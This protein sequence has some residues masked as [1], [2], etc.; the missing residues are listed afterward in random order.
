MKDTN[1]NWSSEDHETVQRLGEPQTQNSALYLW[2][3][4]ISH[5]HISPDAF[6]IQEVLKS[7][8]V[9]SFYWVFIII[10][11]LF[12][13]M[14]QR[15]EVNFQPLPFP[16]SWKVRLIPCRSKPQSCNYKVQGTSM[17]NSFQL[18]LTK[19]QAESEGLVHNKDMPITRGILISLLRSRGKDKINA[20]LHT[21]VCLGLCYSFFLSK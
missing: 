6:T 21:R 14:G 10:V 8:E 11:W 7:L 18:S 17:V 15:A 9:Q 16:G 2:S 19:T 3:Y 4:N 5:F 1:L 12:Y 13:P 20:F